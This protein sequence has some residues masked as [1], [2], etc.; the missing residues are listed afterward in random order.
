MLLD[1]REVYGADFPEIFRVLMTRSARLWVK[2]KEMKPYEEAGPNPIF[3]NLKKN[4]R[5]KCR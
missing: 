2:E 1:L 5:G 4:A 3:S